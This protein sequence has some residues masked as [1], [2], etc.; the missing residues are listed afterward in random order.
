MNATTILIGIGANLPSQRYGSP[1][2]TVE[3]ALAA[4]DAHPDI[5]VMRRSRWFES[6]PVPLSDQPWY[7]N[8]ACSVST[9]LSARA[10]L[11]VLH[12]IEMRFGRVRSE[13][14]AAR[15]LDLDL[16]AYG[17]LVT[18]EAQ[19][20]N[21]PHPRLHERAFVLLPLR[22]LVPGWVHPR[23]GAS[24]QDLIAALSDDQTIR[25][26]EPLPGVQGDDYDDER[27]EE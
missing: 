25:P 14:N 13:K 3:A 2:R 5:C 10:L 18:T 27:G 23:S 8:G 26:M 11:D 4:L 22:D 9:E 19:G 1:I 20:F 24:L 15:V 16:L 6:A 21:V 7:V 12:G 17:H